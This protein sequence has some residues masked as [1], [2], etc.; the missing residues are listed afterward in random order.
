MRKLDQKLIRD[1]RRTWA[2]AVAIALVLA[3][4]IATLVLANGAYRSLFET[5]AAYYERYRF[6]DIFATARRVPQDVAR[7]IAALPGIQAA[8]PRV[9]ATALLDIDG[10]AQP[11]TG[12]IL[13]L[14][15]HGGQPR[16]NALY[17]RAGR[18]PEPLRDDEA[19]VNETFA[20]A[21]KLHPGGALKAILNGRKRTLRIVGIAMSPEFVYALGPGDIVPDDKRFGVVWLSETAAQA[22]FDLK[23]AFNSI[24]VKMMR[25][26]NH[27]VALA[28]IDRLLQRYGPRG[29]AA[30][31]AG[32][33][34]PDQHDARASGRHGTGADRSAEGARL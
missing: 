2:Q 20:K 31:P 3:A 10:F 9:Q 27:D 5:R 30:V 6:A 34:F 32:G 26:F 28:E 17:L 22:A 18:L 15:K 12:L 21:H 19:V 33:R 14:P 13:S 11:A 25:G 23:G 4:G 16:V 8:E 1:L 29:A 7:R 24:S